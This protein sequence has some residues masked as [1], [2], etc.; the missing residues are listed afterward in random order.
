M[1][2]ECIDFDAHQIITEDVGV[3]EQNFKCVIGAWVCLSDIFTR[4]VGITN[5][6]RATV[7]E[8][9]S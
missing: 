5:P 4:R 9:W 7:A 6:I 1:F 2:R 3:G 8:D